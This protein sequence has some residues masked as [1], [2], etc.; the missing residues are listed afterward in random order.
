MVRAEWTT[1]RPR[2]VSCDPVRSSFEEVCEGITVD[3]IDVALLGK[4]NVV[5]TY[6]RKERP[7]FSWWPRELSSLEVSLPRAPK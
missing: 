7:S 3:T 2:V 1:F 6:D 4:D 5:G